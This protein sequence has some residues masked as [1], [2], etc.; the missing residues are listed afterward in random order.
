M[1]NGL[2]F[3]FVDMREPEKVKTALKK[4]T[5][6]VFI[7]TPSNPLMRLV[8]IAEV[9]HIV[10]EYNPKIL[11]VVDNTFMTPY[12]QARNTLFSISSYI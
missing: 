9:S 2:E 11:L 7:E 3:T 8:D 6:M 4:T 10:H 5:K 12:F 1:K